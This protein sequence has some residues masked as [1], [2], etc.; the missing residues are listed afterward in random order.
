MRMTNDYKAAMAQILV[1]GGRP[2]RNLDRAAESIRRAASQGARLVV[3]PECLDLGW[4][5]PSAANSRS[6]ARARMSNGFQ[7]PRARRASTSPPV[8]L[9]AQASASIMQP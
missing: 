3:L 5:D 7:R 1:E 6:Q 9:S 8:W 4:T 2:Q